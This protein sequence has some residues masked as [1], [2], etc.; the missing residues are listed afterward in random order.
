[1]T[2]KNGCPTGK[3]KIGNTCIPQDSITLN[4][5]RKEAKKIGY[6]IQAHTT[7]F[8][9]LARTTRTTINILDK[10]KKFICGSSANVYARDDMQ[11]HKKAFALMRKYKGKVY[12]SKGKKAIL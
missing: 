4:E 9:D 11:R 6:T 3:K 1:M 7:G 10:N 2:E 5:L 8:H 12:D